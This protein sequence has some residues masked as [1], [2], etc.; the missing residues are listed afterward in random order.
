MR[1]YVNLK[2]KEEKDQYFLPFLPN[3]KAK[4]LL[5]TTPYKYKSMFDSLMKVS[6]GGA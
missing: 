1:M 5:L 4:P 3:P 6:E 2:R